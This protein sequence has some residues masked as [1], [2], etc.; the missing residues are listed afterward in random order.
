MTETDREQALKEGLLQLKQN[1]ERLGQQ[2]WQ[3]PQRRQAQ[4]ELERMLKDLEANLQQ[5]GQEFRQSE[6][7]QQLKR[8]L[9]RIKQ[10]FDSGELERK[11]K[12]ELVKLVGQ[13]NERLESW[14]TDSEPAVGTGRPAEQGSGDDG[15]V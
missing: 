13:L 1:L 14:L 9:D 8:E 7:G 10:E 4:A 5:A 6:A 2:A 12:M 3:S 15:V 11:A